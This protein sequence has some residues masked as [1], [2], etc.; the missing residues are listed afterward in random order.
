MGPSG[1]GK[2]EL[3]KALAE[4]VYGSEEALVRIDMSEYME[5]HSVS[6]LVGSPPG[7]IGYD[8]GG[9]LTERIR[10]RPYCVLL[11]DEIEKAHPDVW[12]ILLQLL[13]EGCLTDSQGRKVDFR[14]VILIM[15]GNIGSM[16]PKSAGFGATAEGAVMAEAKRTFRP[17]L[18]NRIDEIIVFAPLG[19][20]SL[21]RIARRL[22]CELSARADSAGCE[23]VV[24]DA[25]IEHLAASPGARQLRRAVETELEDELARL[26]LSG[27]ERAVATVEGG[28]IQVTAGQ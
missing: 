21:A 15:T 4:A 14:N 1:V 11:L 25:V 24:E 9:Q 16:S 23:L 5:R 6:R 12:N 3:A 28:R 22:I 20:D 8:D 2:T 27:T 26:L 13:E 19:P 7:Y 18:L 17:E 10:R